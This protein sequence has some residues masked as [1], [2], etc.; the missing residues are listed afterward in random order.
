MSASTVSLTL[1]RRLA[2]ALLCAVEIQLD[3][4]IEDEEKT[5]YVEDVRAA[6]AALLA[7]VEASR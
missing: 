7:V 5:E 6:H 4:M 1:T 3:H 2:V